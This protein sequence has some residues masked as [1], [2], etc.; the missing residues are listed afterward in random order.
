M[1][2]PLRRGVGAAILAVTVG[3]VVAETFVERT[4]VGTMYVVGFARG[5]S[6]ADG[7]DAT[8]LEAASLLKAHPELK[9]S[10]VAYTEPGGDAAADQALSDQRAAAAAD[11][12]ETDGVD[13]SKV[14]ALGGGAG[15]P[16]PRLPD[17]SD[18]EWQ[19]RMARAEIRISR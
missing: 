8:L 4:T 16:L 10:I 18:A 7:A 1:S 17:E 5:A 2:F 15:K 9:A 19:H 6:L 11:A 12:L 13:A 3:I 14:T